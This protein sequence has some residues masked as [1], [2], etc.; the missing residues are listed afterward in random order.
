M[1]LI[2]QYYTDFVRAGAALGIAEQ[3]RLKEINAEAALL[4]T[5]FSQNV[6]CLLYTSDAADE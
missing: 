6:L 1:R 5:Q 3:A 2:E 4:Q